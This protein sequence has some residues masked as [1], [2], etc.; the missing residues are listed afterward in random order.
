M[1][2]HVRTAKQAALRNAEALCAD[3]R[4]HR[5]SVHVD[6]MVPRG[7]AIAAV[8]S[9]WLQQEAEVEAGAWLAGQ[10]HGHEACHAIVVRHACHGA[11]KHHLRMERADSNGQVPTLPNPTGLWQ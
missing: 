4:L 8:G 10:H 5:R 2:L 6:A 1:S 11:G 9:A 3:G 7:G